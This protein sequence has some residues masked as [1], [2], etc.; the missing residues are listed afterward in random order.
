MMLER[1]SFRAS[2]DEAVLVAERE[3]AE[4]ERKYK[5]LARLAAEV[6]GGS[7]EEDQS[8]DALVKGLKAAKVAVQRAKAELT[9]AQRFAASRANAWSAYRRSSTRR[10]TSPPHGTGSATRNARSFSTTGSWTF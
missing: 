9:E 5:G 3:V 2:A 6:A 10:A 1:D 7:D 4:R 8:D